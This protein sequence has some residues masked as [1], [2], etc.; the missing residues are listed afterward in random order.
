[1]RFPARRRISVRRRQHTL[2]ERDVDALDCVRDVFGVDFDNRPDPA[3][4]VRY[5][6][7]PRFGR[8]P[9]ADNGHTAPVPLHRGRHL[10]PNMHI[11]LWR[12]RENDRL[13]SLTRYAKH[14]TH[15]FEA[16]FVG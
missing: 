14:G 11:T 8:K 13:N 5:G 7:K 3:F 2:G 12:A 9:R 6:R 16:P 15:G 4:E 10:R 1:M